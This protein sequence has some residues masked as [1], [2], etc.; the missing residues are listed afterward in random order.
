MEP[1]NNKDSRKLFFGRVYGCEEDCPSQFEEISVEILKKCG[2]LPLAIITVASLLASR[3]ERLRDEWESIKN[4]LG[5]QFAINPTL[6]GMKNILNL[7]YMHLPFYLRACFLYLGMYPEDCE[8]ESNDLVRQW[9][10]EGLVSN[11]H[12]QDLEVVAKSYFNELINRNMIQPVL[13]EHG[14]VLSCR[15]HDMLV[16][17]ILSKCAEDN[18]ISVA[19]NQEDI[20]ILDRCEYKVRRLSLISSSRGTQLPTIPTSLSQV[21]SFAL[22]GDS[23][24][25][26]PLSEFRYLRVLVFEHAGNRK[27]VIRLTDIGLLF[28]LRY[29]KVSV[30]S[31]VMIL[32][33]KIGGL[34][35]L[36]T[37][38][39]YGAAFSIPSDIVALPRLSHLILPYEYDPGS[40]PEGIESIKSL[41][42]LHCSG[43]ERSSLQDI[44][45]LGELTNLRELRIS[46]WELEGDVLDALISSIGKLCKLRSFVLNIKSRKHDENHLFSLSNTPPHIEKLEM[47]RWTFK[48]VPKWICDL[49]YLHTLSLF[50]EHLSTDDVH[51]LGKLPG[52]VHLCLNVLR[53][54]EDS[55]AAVVCT[56]LFP[57][58][59][60]LRLRSDRDDSTA[61]MEFEAGA[62]P[63]LRRLVLQIRDKWGGVMP[64]GMEHLLALEQIHIDNMFSVHDDSDVESAFRDAAQVHPSRPSVSMC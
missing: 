47:Q 21:R 55:A 38:E 11:L 1:L 33:A 49:Q 7:S 10:A 44:K 52:L 17:L 19:Y 25:P 64:V 24:Y 22:F 36:E 18:F 50:V 40:L 62:M 35:H 37:L 6:E 23:S 56:R 29:L 3:P 27:V 16:D 13:T 54:P 28:Q 30:Q 43:M 46:T 12:G 39:M 60:H 53:V 20:A 32:P 58:L 26:C 51:I 41:R 4:S 2:G 63:K 9:I 42:T 48:G 5:A 15:V 31:G 8:I 57:V 45:G 61:C 34:L 59:Q 14:E